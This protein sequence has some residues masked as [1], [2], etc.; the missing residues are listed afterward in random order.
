MT[1]E[2]ETVVE[3]N[4]PA[5]VAEG[6]RIVEALLF[7]SSEPLGPDQLSNFLPE[8]CDLSQVLEHLRAL[9]SNRGVNLVSVAGKLAFRTA[10]DLSYLMYREAV[11]QR[12]LSRA[13]L[14]TLAIN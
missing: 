3:G 8:N 6:S 2:Q 4:H 10:E 14:E 7:A 11:E 13:A 12:K 9:Y 1:D 5:S